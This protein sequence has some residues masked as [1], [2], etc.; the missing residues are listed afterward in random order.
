MNS[1]R[2]LTL[3]SIFCGLTEL[4]YAGPPGPLG[5]PGPNGPMGPPGGPMGP[6]GGPGA[7]LGAPG[8]EIGDGVVGFA[9]AAA[10]VLGFLMLPRIRRLLQSKVV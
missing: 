3:A 5:P 2:S 8:P 9:V 1:S 7:P 10:L 6:P 4:A